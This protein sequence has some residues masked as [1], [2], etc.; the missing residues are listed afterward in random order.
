MFFFF[1]F[2]IQQRKEVIQ[3]LLPSAVTSLG[4][5]AELLGLAIGRSQRLDQRVSKSRGATGT[6]PPRSFCFAALSLFGCALPALTFEYEPA[7][8]AA[9]GCAAKTGHPIHAFRNGRVQVDSLLGLCF[10]NREGSHRRLFRF[11]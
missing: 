11:G 4:S 10:T 8:I 3:C 9:A 5:P 7:H 6:I 1:F 2:F